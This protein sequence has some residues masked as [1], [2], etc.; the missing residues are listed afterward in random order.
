MT[1]QALIRIELV[2]H[3][4]IRHQKGLNPNRSRPFAYLFTVN[5]TE[6][7][8]H[9]QLNHLFCLREGKHFIRDPM[10]I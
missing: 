8:I 3:S 4:D 7:L 1:E 2:H 9:I 6:L 5:F 10:I